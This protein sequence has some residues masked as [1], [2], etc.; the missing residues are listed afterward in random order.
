MTKEREKRHRERTRITTCMPDAIPI[1]QICGYR[2]QRGGSGFR[3]VV[4]YSEAALPDWGV[5]RRGHSQSNIILLRLFEDFSLSVNKNNNYYCTTGR[6]RALVSVHALYIA[7]FLHY[8][9]S[10]ILESYITA[11]SYNFLEGPL[12]LFPIHF[13]FSAPLLHIQSPAVSPSDPKFRIIC[14]FQERVIGP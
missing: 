1:L 5:S 9:V 12:V 4:F 7:A 6:D 10:N 3:R 14:S 11:S 13:P 8:L 2:V